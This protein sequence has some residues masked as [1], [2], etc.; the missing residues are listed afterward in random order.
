VPFWTR[1]MYPVTRLLPN[2]LLLSSFFLELFS[3]LFFIY[4]ALA[5]YSS[6][7]FFKLQFF[8]YLFILYYAL[9]SYPSVILF[10]FSLSHLVIYFFSLRTCFLIFWYFLFFSLLFFACF[11]LVFPFQTRPIYPVTRELERE[12]P[13]QVSLATKNT[14]QKYSL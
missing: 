8:S 7:I 13:V 12:W 5:S 14:I 1:P 10:F 4:Y 2:L 11:P 6:V 9:A 3:Y